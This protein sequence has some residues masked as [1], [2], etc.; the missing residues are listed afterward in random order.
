[1]R[2]PASPSGGGSG[3]ATDL[4]GRWKSPAMV[5]RQPASAG[6]RCSTHEWGPGMLASSGAPRS[7]G[8]GS[9][10]RPERKAVARHDL[11]HGALNASTRLRST[12]AGRD[13][14]PS[15]GVTWRSRGH[16]Q[17]RIRV[18]AVLGLEPEVKKTAGHD[19]LE[20]QQAQGSIGHRHRSRDGDATDSFMEQSPGDAGRRNGNRKY[21]QQCG[22]ES[23][24]RRRRREGIGRGDAA[25]L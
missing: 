20:K 13:S 19:Q 9:V 22:R 14:P 7:S 10:R 2:L 23:D 4:T 18:R 15:R 8:F 17:T 5:A 25:R 1:M 3:S 12:T 6:C 24:R 16:G 11:G 21:W